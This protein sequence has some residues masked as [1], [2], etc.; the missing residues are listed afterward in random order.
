MEPLTSLNLDTGSKKNAGIAPGD[1]GNSLTSLNLDTASKKESASKAFSAL[2]RPPKLAM[3]DEPT[4]RFILEEDNEAA[5]W[6]KRALFLFAVMF[7]AC[8]LVVLGFLSGWIQRHE[9]LVALQAEEQPHHEQTTFLV[10]PPD[11]EKELR[12]P[13]TNILSDKNRLAH[14]PS[15]KIN[16][17]G[18]TMPYM[19]GNT[20]L[21]KAAGGSPPPPLK[22]VMPVAPGP[23][24]PPK[25]EVA[26]AQHPPQPKPQPPAPKPK[27]M[28]S[29]INP[30]PKP[31]QQL[32]ARLGLTS[33]EEAI[34]QSLQDVARGRSTGAIPGAGDSPDQLNNL[35]PNFSTSGP[36]ILSNTRGVDFGPYLAQILMIV[37]NNWY[38]VIPES[39]RLGEQGRCAI[40]F[41]IQKDG[42]VPKLELVSSSGKPPLD[43]AAESGIRSST[44]F[45]PLPAEFTGNHLLLQFNFFYNM[46]P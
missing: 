35:N 16:P 18:L 38:A 41:D 36:I 17:K 34:Q 39:A 29:D 23:Q 10:M 46:N 22:R 1:N 11:L 12:K 44:P 2:K 30:P 19:R 6:R 28:L 3:N 13:R 40:V 25:K 26:Q 45:P 27:I 9:R 31:D 33:P 43:L 15:P 5:K 7:E 37:R 21:P 14:G 8:M 4:L 32:A 42:S 20:H 24:S